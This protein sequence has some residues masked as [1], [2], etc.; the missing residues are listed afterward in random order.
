MAIVYLIRSV[1]LCLILLPGVVRA[2]EPD[3]T[4]LL[5]GLGSRTVAL[6]AVQT[7]E[8]LAARILYVESTGILSLQGNWPEDPANNWPEDAEAPKVVYDVFNLYSRMVAEVAPLRRIAAREGVFTDEERA[9]FTSLVDDLESFIIQS[10][11]LYDLMKAVRTDEANLF[12]RDEIR[13]KYEGI[14]AQSYTIG[15][16]ISQD[17]SRIALA[18]RRLR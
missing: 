12:Y 10:K 14:V 8:R 15:A 6:E 5:A 3:A 1:L 18:A 11:L 2:Q 16:S 4:S 17:I 13:G 9:K 7:V